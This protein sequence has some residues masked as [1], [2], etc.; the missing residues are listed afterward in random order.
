MYATWKE[1]NHLYTESASINNLI[2]RLP[3][4]S[5][6]IDTET[7]KFEDKKY[8]RNRNY[9]LYRI[10]MKIGVHVDWG[11]T[12]LKK[13][14]SSK[15][16]CLLRTCSIFVW[17]CQHSWYVVDKHSKRMIQSNAFSCEYWKHTKHHYHH[18]NK[19]YISGN[20]FTQ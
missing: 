7:M 17:M 18:R 15:E 1:R 10:H 12:W 4:Y 9:E 20:N 19:E 14:Y 6:R 8:S 11:S 5:L 2:K 13:L 16:L 3:H